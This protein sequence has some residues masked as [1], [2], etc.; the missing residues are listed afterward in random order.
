M[1]F[2]P[3][4]LNSQEVSIPSQ[5]NLSYEKVESIKNFESS[6]ISHNFKTYPTITMKILD[7][8]K[9]MK[10]RIVLK[11]LPTSNIHKFITDKSFMQPEENIGKMKKLVTVIFKRIS[12][13]IIRPD[14]ALRIFWDILLL[15][16]MIQCFLYIP[17][18]IS[19]DLTIEFDQTINKMA[20]IIFFVDI[21]LNCIT[22]QYVEGLLV[23]DPK[24]ICGKTYSF[25]I[26]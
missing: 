2:G 9:K 5:D 20:P 21:A 15:L 17:F 16:I 1:K 26:L 25:M 19:F 6:K 12:T 4:V 11:V 10:A 13:L 22:G 23:L 18:Q 7:F 14:N 8:M 24:K 3:R